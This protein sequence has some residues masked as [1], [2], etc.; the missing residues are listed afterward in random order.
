MLIQSFSHEGPLSC[1]QPAQSLSPQMLGEVRE[2]SQFSHSIVSHSLQ[3][4]GLQHARP[5]CPSLTPG[6]Y[7]NSSIALVMPSNHLILCHHLLLPSIFPSIRA[8]SKEL[9]LR[10]R[11]PKYW[12]FSFGSP[13][14]PR[15]SQESSPT[16]QFKGINSLTLSL[17]T[18]QL[19]Y[20]YTYIWIY[21]K[22]YT[23]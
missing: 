8:F 4:H 21:I 11:W 17:F 19:S 7:S 20:L 5:P 9:V 13:C 2:L 1:P 3:P 16:P 6:A 14:S 23:F 18:V 10:I 12:S 22:A 15:D